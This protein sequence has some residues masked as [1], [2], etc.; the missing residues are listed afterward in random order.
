MTDSNHH[1]VDEDLTL[2]FRWR[3]G[4]HG[5]Y[6]AVSSIIG[7]FVLVLHV[8]PTAPKRQIDLTRVDLIHVHY[9]TA[10]DEPPEKE[11]PFRDPR[12]IRPP[13]KHS[14]QAAM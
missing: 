1:F 9:L 2:H 7:L 11:D 5:I 3:W 6:L 4:E 13:G 10:A 8:V 14:I 12:L